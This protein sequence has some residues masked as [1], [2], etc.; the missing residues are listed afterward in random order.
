MA[1]T[2]RTYY[3]QQRETL[4]QEHLN[5]NSDIPMKYSN[6]ST[7]SVVSVDKCNEM[8]KS[9]SLTNYLITSE[10]RLSDLEQYR[11]E[12]AISVSNREAETD[13]GRRSNT[14]KEKLENLIDMR[15]PCATEESSRVF[16]ELNSEKGKFLL[17]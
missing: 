2:S 17:C 10:G 14:A 13:R 15:F 16:L 5:S 11:R 4:F 12:S 1:Q 6:P 3:P 7:V 9:S 8:R